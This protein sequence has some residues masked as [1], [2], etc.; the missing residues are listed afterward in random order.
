MTEHLSVPEA[1]H[2]EDP[3]GGGGDTCSKEYMV[4]PHTNY[5]RFILKQLLLLICKGGK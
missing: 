3:L 4:V 5:L 1:P 2:L